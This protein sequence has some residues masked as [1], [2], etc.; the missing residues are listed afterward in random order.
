MSSASTILGDLGQAVVDAI[1]AEGGKAVFVAGDI[2]EEDTST[3]M[4]AAA[5]DNFGGLDLAINNAGVMDGVYS[6]RAAGLCQPEGP[7]LRPAS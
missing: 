2:A 5:V 7:G 3:R 6:G 4:I 1:V